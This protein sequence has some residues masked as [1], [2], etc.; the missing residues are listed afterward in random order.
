MKAAVKRI[1][2]FLNPSGS[3]DFKVVNQTAHFQL[4][5]ENQ[6]VAYLNFENDHWSFKYS[7]NFKETSGIKPLANFPDINKEY[8]S[9]TL[10]PF[11]VA[12][13]PSLSRKRV[14]QAAEEKGIKDND[15]ISLLTQ[16]GRKTITNPFELISME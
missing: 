10:W 11:F 6:P 12:R 7:E 3:E 5:L 16:F 1:K 2:E 4:N 13:I 9:E 15:M 8:K 14:K